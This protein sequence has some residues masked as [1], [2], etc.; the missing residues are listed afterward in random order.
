MEPRAVFFCIS[1]AVVESIVAALPEF[2]GFGDDAEAA[3]EVRAG[4]MAVGK[5]LLKFFVSVQKILA[6]GN[7]SALVRDPSADAAPSWTAV[8][9]GGGFFLTEFFNRSGNFDLALQ[10][11][12]REKEGGAWVFGEVFPFA[13]RVVCEKHKAP[14][15]KAF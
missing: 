4:D 11:N 7:F 13:A 2:D 14:F 9:V 5:A 12:P 6:R 15:I 8:E 1:D 3:P 10:G